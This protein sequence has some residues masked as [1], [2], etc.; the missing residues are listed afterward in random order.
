MINSAI[1]NFESLVPVTNEEI[2]IEDILFEGVHVRVY[3]PP[4]Q[5]GK[6]RRAVMFIHGGGWALGAPSMSKMNHYI[7]FLMNQV[8]G[9]ALPSCYVHWIVRELCFHV[10][11]F[12]SHQSWGHMTVSAD[13]WQLIWMQWL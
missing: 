10:T 3:Q 8:A 4:R 11:A 9:L 6:L 13:R 5:D 2:Q 12:I 7:S 1:I